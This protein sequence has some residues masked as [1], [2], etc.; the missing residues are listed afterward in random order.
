VWREVRPTRRSRLAL[1]MQQLTAAIFAIAVIACPG[2]VAAQECPDGRVATE[3]SEAQCCWPGQQ[4]NAE[5][6]VCTGAPACPEGYV[7]HGDDCMSRA[8]EPVPRPPGAADAPRPPL[9]PQAWDSESPPAPERV[10]RTASPGRWLIFSGAVAAAIG[11]TGLV[12]GG[13]AY[14]VADVGSVVWDY[15][16]PGNTVG[17]SSVSLLTGIVL[18]VTGAVQNGNARSVAANEVRVIPAVA[19]SDRGDGV[20]IG[21]TGFF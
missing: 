10:R 12:L 19:T 17:L 20:V 7:A 1:M 2:A 11:A 16:R 5:A 9:V 18:L 6:A 3:Q 13:L 8:I 14:V 21:A 4:W 15:T